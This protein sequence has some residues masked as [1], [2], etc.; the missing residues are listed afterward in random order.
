MKKFI[1][2]RQK[3]A[4]FY[5]DK[6]KNISWLKPQYIPDYIS[7][8][9][10]QSYVGYVDPKKSPK[11]RNE[12]M[13]YLDMKGISTRPGTHAIHMLSFYKNEYG[14]KADQFIGAKLCDQNTI[15][16]PLHNKMVPE[17]YQY[18]VDTLKEI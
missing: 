9:A 17:D 12:I 13:D 18:V 5:N 6:I 15:A 2:D 4:S 7:Q 16:I 11:E 8:H 10:W 3:W 1:E 14:F